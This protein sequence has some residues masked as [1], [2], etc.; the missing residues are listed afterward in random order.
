[1][2]FVNRGPDTK[3]FRI[4]HYRNL[5]LT[6]RNGIFCKNSEN[7][8]PDYI[9]IGHLQL[10]NDRGTK[11]VSISPFG[12]LNDY[13]PFYFAPRS[14][15]LYSISKGH[16][17]NFNGNQSDIVYLVSNINEIIN[18]DRPF[19]FTDAHAYIMFANEYNDI[20]HLDKVDWTVMNSRFWNRTVDDPDRMSKRM[21][22]FLVY[23]FVPVNCILEV[24]VF[25]QEKLDYVNQILSVLNLTIQSRICKAWY[26]A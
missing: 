17:A 4:T 5:A 11:R 2:P 14:P 8:D 10:I 24:V 16:V 22:E 19:I 20:Q 25:N 3:I 21:A 18:A 9:D 15:M 6:L 23:H 12:V 26:Y 13:V 7:C 1:M